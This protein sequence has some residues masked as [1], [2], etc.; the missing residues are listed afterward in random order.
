M[1][2][3]VKNLLLAG[4]GAISYSQEKLK[5]TIDDLIAKGELTREQGEKVVADWVERG[6]DEKD[7]WSERF[8]DEVRRIVEKVGAVSRQD[9]DALRARVAELEKK[10]TRH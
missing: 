1:I 8:Q 6:R 9:F 3:S 5:G 4:L 10:L 2:D 7:Q